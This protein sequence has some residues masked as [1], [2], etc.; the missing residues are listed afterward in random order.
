M[1]P[2]LA[3]W[4]VSAEA[5][6]ALT[7]AG[8]QVDPSS[9]V[10][11]Q[12]LRRDFPPDHAAAALTQI[13]LRRKG[14]SKFGAEAARL[15]FTPGGLEQATRG[16]V[17]DW[18][19]MRLRSAGAVSIV[20]VGCGLG[21]DSLACAA[22]GI[23]VTAIESDEVTAIFAA[24]N[25]GP[26]AKVLHADATA[27]VGARQLSEALDAGS[28]VFIDPARRT[29]R[30]RSWQVSDFTPDWGFSLGVLRGRT[31]CL[32]AAPGLPKDLIP[33]WVSAIWVS[34]RH[35][36]VETSLWSGVGEPGRRSALLLPAVH[37]LPVT[38]RKSA[39]AGPIGRFLYEP[40]PA[41]IRSGGVDDLAVQL[42]AHRVSE[43]IAYLTAEECQPTPFASVFE[44]N[45]VLPY[46]E[47]ALRSWVKEGQIGILEI[48]VRGIDVD[49]AV[50]RRRLRPKGAGT[51]TLILTPTTSG[52][53]AIVGTR[54][55][56]VLMPR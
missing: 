18:R 49:P 55:D 34:H 12:R 47:K 54:L 15:F 26:E 29:G 20:D 2:D 17:A 5:E 9:L 3:R 1:E 45:Q 27:G 10:A 37:E 46:D 24:A 7:L 31:G 25:L 23:S 51:A 40:D 4:L 14:V 21:A 28:A 19:A 48:K 39:G 8:E 41:V 52:S 43:G 53:R 38:G 32:K 50:L 6:P 42:G 36:V 56:R 44:V 30:G 33:E 35:D 16:S 22:Q 13:E 11:A